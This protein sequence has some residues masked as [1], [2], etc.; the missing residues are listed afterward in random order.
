M[1]KRP[2]CKEF[3]VLKDSERTFDELKSFHTYDLLVLL[4]L[5][6]QERSKTFDLMRSLK[7]VSENPEIQKDMVLYSEEQYVYYTKRMKVIEGLLID[8]MGYKPKRVDDK[9]LISLKSKI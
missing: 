4:R 6:R 2:S 8:R 1:V 7:K 3:V 9:L 5:V